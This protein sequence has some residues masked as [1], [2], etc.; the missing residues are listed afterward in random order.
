MNLSLSFYNAQNSS[1]NSS[2]V[3]LMCTYCTF[4]YIL[5]YNV[6]G[7]VFYFTKMKS[8]A[9]FWMQPYYFSIW[10]FN[11]TFVQKVLL[12]TYA[13]L[14]LDKYLLCVSRVV[15]I[16]NTGVFYMLLRRYTLKSVKNVPLILFHVVFNWVILT[17]NIWYPKKGG[18]CISYHLLL[19]GIKNNKKI[20]N[21]AA[22][23]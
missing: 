20:R 14:S 16:K 18:L 10:Q 9:I 17:N 15:F 13:K 1:P 7:R 19:M 8:S 4:F 12:K 11:M 5:R 3:H 2:S 23:S 21:G 22:A 6:S